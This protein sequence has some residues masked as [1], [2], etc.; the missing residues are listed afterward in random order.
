MQIVEKALREIKNLFLMLDFGNAILNALI[1][2]LAC[3]LISNLFNFQWYYGLIPSITLLIY[4][5]TKSFATNKYYIVETKVPALNEQLRTVADN[6]NRSNFIVDGL[7]DDVL[8]KMKNVKTSYFIDYRTL[9]ARLMMLGGLSFLIILIALLNVDLAGTITQAVIEPLKA[10][11]IRN[12]G[13]EVIYFN[14]SITEGNLSEILGNKSL[15]KLGKKELKLTI[16]TLLSEADPSSIK[17]V[18]AESFSPPNFPKE[19]YTSYDVS[20]N[21]KIAKE[22]QEVVKNYFQKITN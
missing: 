20:Y 16:N 9:I 5:I 10:A 4:Q 22:N 1:T 17:N 7:K 13:Q 14:V 18:E 19:I 15:A 6:V 2:F 21:E 11:A 3:L 12:S 8:K